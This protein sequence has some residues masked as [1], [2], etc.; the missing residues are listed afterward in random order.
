MNGDQAEGLRSL[1]EQIKEGGPEI[2]AAHGRMMDVPTL[3]SIIRTEIDGEGRSLKIPVYGWFEGKFYE[4][5][6]ASKPPQSAIVPILRSALVTLLSADKR[7][8]FQMSGDDKDGFLAAL[9][10]QKRAMEQAESA[11]REL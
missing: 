10:F 4:Q 5:G 11:L 1:V 8:A 7:L 9:A 3:K 2:D 6:K